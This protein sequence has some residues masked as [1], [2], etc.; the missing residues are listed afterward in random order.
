M[1]E[2]VILTEL[3]EKPVGWT[4]TCIL[5]LNFGGGK[6][7]ASYTIH[8]EQGRTVAGLHYSYDTSKG[9][10]RGFTLDGD[11]Q[12]YQTWPELRAGYAKAH[13]QL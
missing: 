10:Q 11:E 2:S 6:G 9:G 12:F 8:D 5:H 13:A 7:A 3:P 1:S 4:R